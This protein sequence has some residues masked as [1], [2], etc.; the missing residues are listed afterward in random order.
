VIHQGGTSR[1]RRSG[2]H[3]N[4]NHTV[5]GFIQSVRESQVSTPDFSVV[6]NPAVSGCGHNANVAPAANCVT[7]LRPTLPVPR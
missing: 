4:M 7:T 1:G 6:D 5:R 3:Q 2:P